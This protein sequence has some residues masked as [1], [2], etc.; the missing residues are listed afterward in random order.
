MPFISMTA[1]LFSDTG[2][3]FRKNVFERYD[4]WVPW[5]KEVTNVFYDLTLFNSDTMVLPPALKNKKEIAEMYFRLEVEEIEHVR[6][7][8]ELMDWLGSVGGIVEVLTKLATFI[9]GS[10]MSFNS[11][12]EIIHH[13]YH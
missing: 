12:L 7:F 3:R 11:G 13:I 2:Y 1:G 8:F 5:S 9:L 10:Y 4:T 6:I